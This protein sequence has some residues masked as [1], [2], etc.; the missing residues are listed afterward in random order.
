MRIQ[1][2]K[3]RV[4]LLALAV[5]GALLAMCAM[6]AHAEDDEVAALTNPTSFVEIGALNTS[7]SSAKFGEYSG[8]DKSG[9]TVIGN[10]GVRGGDACG[11]SNGTKRWSFTGSDLGTT[12][13]ALGATMSNQGQWNFGIN[14]DELRHNISDT[15]Q[16]PLQGSMGGNTFTAATQRR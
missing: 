10:F 3:M 8:L 2:G 9:G 7:R 11:D 16:T 12:S 6:P 4:S 15:Y 14:Y 13:R 5:E 1:N